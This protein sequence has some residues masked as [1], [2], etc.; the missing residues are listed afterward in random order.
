MW[1]LA[2]KGLCFQKSHHLAHGNDT[3]RGYNSTLENI[4]RFTGVKS[5]CSRPCWKHPTNSSIPF[6]RQSQ[7]ALTSC[8]LH[9]LVKHSTTTQTKT[10]DYGMLAKGHYAKRNTIGFSP[11]ERGY[12]WSGC[13]LHLYKLRMGDT[14]QPR[15]WNQSR[16]TR[17]KLMFKDKS[18]R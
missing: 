2:I 11:D 4:D 10:T 1:S 8:C 18:Y 14:L 15:V 17:Y 9:S 16:Y 13:F 12:G 6:R 5:M 7:V 3:V